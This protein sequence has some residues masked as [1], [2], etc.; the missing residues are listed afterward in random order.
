MLTLIKTTEGELSDPARA[1]A[2]TDYSWSIFQTD[3]CTNISFT[4]P[5]VA[6]LVSMERLVK[7]VHTFLYFSLA[8]LLVHDLLN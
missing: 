2:L 3:V 7:L 6:L 4:S 1:N 5:D 8:G